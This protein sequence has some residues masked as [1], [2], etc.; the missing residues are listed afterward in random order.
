MSD[1]NKTMMSAKQGKKAKK[2]PHSLSVG[3]VKARFAEA[4]TLADAVGLIREAG[5]L[6]KLYA[7]YTTLR[8]LLPMI[9]S[10]FWWLT[11]ATSKQFDDLIESRKY[12]EKVTLENLYFA[13]F[14]YQQSESA[15]MWRLYS[16]CGEDA[17]RIVLTK[18]VLKRWLDGLTAHTLHVYPIRDGKV[19]KAKELAVG[20]ASVHDVLYASVEDVDGDGARARSLCWNDCFTKEIVD[21]RK[22]KCSAAA[23]G[24]L[25]DYE[26]RFEYESRLAIEIEGNDGNDCD[27]IAVEIPKDVLAAMKFTRSPWVCYEKRI[28]DALRDARVV[29]ATKSDSVKQSVLTGGLE[30]WR[31]KTKHFEKGE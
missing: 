13:C 8:T 15:A 30:K 29:H 19:D 26:W 28:V 9:E 18:T 23:S 17:V 1:H 6:H 24:V 25:K 14:S 7:H 2:T 5:V 27:R 21:L 16:D 20:K 3:D 4:T 12:G 10:G 31:T 22:E 11:R